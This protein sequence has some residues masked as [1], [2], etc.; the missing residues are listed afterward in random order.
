VI[1]I[2]DK[3]IEFTKL[4]ITS[5]DTQQSINVY[6]KIPETYDRE[7]FIIKMEEEVYKILDKGDRIGLYEATKKFIFSNNI[8]YYDLYKIG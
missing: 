6:I 1:K 8:E 2:V 4:T 7:D 3:I 5:Q